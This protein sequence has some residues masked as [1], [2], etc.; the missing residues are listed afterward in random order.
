MVVRR[1]YLDGILIGVR[2]HGP[3]IPAELREVVFRPFFRIDSSRNRDTGGH[4]LGLAIARQLADTQGWSLTIKPRVSGGTS[5]WIAIPF[6]AA[7]N[8]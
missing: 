7:T 8:F 4:G 5:I 6:L 3:G 2:D 1:R